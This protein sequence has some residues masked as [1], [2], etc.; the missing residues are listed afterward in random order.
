M[1]CMGGVMG[2]ASASEERRDHDKREMKE[3]ESE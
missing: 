2:L 3:K 1:G